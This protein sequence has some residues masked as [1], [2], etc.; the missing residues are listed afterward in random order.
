MRI[1]IENAGD[2]IVPLTTD[3]ATH[4]QKGILSCDRTEPGLREAISHA[5]DAEG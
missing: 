2:F 3:E 5:H 1:Y 4:S